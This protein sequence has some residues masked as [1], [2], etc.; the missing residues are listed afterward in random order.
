MLV[1]LHGYLIV[2][3][4]QD[5]WILVSFFRVLLSFTTLR[6]IKR[7]NY[8]QYPAF[9]SKQ[10]VVSSTD[11]L[12]TQTKKLKI[13]Y[14]PSYISLCHKAH[15]A[16][17]FSFQPLRF[18]ARVLTF[19]HDCHPAVFLLSSIILLQVVLGRPGLLFPSGLHSRAVTQCSS[20]S[21]FPHDMSNPVPSFTPDFIARSVHS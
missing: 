7:Q 2:L 10:T 14:I 4:A 8:K 6:S 13:S 21:G 19:A 12:P 18:A 20:L 9:S 3:S 1:F 11:I 15:K 5:H 16:L 17:T